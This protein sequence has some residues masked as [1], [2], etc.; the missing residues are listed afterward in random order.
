[1]TS[2]SV[3][4]KEGGE[5]EAKEGPPWYVEFF[6]GDYLSIYGDSFTEARAQTESDCVER[7]LALKPGEQ[8]LDLACGQGRH[9]VLLAKKG[10]RVTG[11]DLQPKYLKLA[12]E[13]AAAAGV[14]IE[15]VHSDMR[16]I[17]FPNQFD[18]VINM[19]T[20]FGYLESDAEEQKVLQAVA[21]ALKPGGRF[22]LDL[23]NR[24]WVV[25][26]YIQ[27]EWRKTP[28]GTLILEHRVFD[29]AAGRINVAYTVIA[30]DGRR[31]ES[32][33]HNARLYTLTE[34]SRML[35]KAGL[36]VTDVHGG[37]QGETYSIQTRR[38]IVVAHKG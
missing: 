15:T 29:L 14:P 25:D 10:L 26:N 27:N 18:A 7:V 22:L 5:G 31:H 19:F 23:L 34:I 28:N 11:L 38:M 20:A 4:A 32:M 30:P 6:Q 2:A 16:V 36:R 8:V 1:M 3:Q 33:G 37:Y 12:E 17:P 13:S 35:V 9:A 21:G 24:E